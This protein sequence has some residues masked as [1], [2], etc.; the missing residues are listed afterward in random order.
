MELQLNRHNKETG[1]RDYLLHIRIMVDSF[2]F[3]SDSSDKRGELNLVAMRE[4]RLQGC[5]WVSLGIL[6]GVFRA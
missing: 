4:L 1:K 3:L 5:C 2:G 6:T